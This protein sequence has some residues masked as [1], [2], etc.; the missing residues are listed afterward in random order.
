MTSTQR[1]LDGRRSSPTSPIFLMCQWS[2]SYRPARPSYEQKPNH[3]R[4][5]RRFGRWSTAQQLLFEIAT[6]EMFPFP[7]KASSRNQ[8]QLTRTLLL[9]LLLQRSPGSLTI[10]DLAGE[11]D[12][13]GRRRFHRTA[14]D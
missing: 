2:G 11:R 5:A 9:G 10:L 14:A 7:T 1:A 8:P 13:L 3:Q 6:H 4:S 12:L